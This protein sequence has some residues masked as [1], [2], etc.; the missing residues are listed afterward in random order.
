MK[1]VIYVVIAYRWG[2][3][4][5]HSYLVG[6]NTKK[7]KAIKMAEKEADYRGG[8]YDCWVYE[9][10]VDWEWNDEYGNKKIVHQAKGIDL[11]KL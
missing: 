11:S 8:K 2:S 3:Q 6:C 5:S 1:P 10:D 4:E 9:T 7:S